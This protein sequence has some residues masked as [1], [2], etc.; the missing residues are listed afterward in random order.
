[1]D[2]KVKSDLIRS[3]REKRAWSQQHLAT[4][5]ALGLRTIQR[6]ELN[7]TA[8]YDSV[9][10]IAACLDLSVSEIRI[11]LQPNH[12]IRKS[13]GISKTYLSA[14]AAAIVGMAVVVSVQGV[15]ADQV[16]L[17]LGVTLSTATDKNEYLSQVLLDTGDEIELRMDEKFSLNVGAEIV[18]GNEIVIAFKVYEFKDEIYSLLGE[19]RL[20]TTGGNQAEVEVGPSDEDGVTF[21]ISVTPQIQ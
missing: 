3:E 19:P 2:M 18:N 20:L 17:D 14:I 6:I 7:G 11:D 21:R 9:Q 13:F 16:K 1:M 10:A 8:S 5:T 4:V 15:A 12:S